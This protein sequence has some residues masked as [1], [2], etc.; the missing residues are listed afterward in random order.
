M[1]I[2]EILQ[3][4]GICLSSVFL[5]LIVI[6]L[7]KLGAVFLPPTQAEL[8]A[9]KEEDNEDD[10]L[11]YLRGKSREEIEEI[12]TT[13]VPPSRPYRRSKSRKQ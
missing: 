1:N 8:D 4:V 11:V 3:T 13:P 12:L 7:L 5:L 6:I 10:I 9:M 2:L